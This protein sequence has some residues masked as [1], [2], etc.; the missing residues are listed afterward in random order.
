MSADNKPQAQYGNVK[1][2]DSS[3]TF[4]A[5]RLR[6]AYSGC[7][8]NTIVFCV[9]ENELEFANWLIDLQNH[10]QDTVSRDP[11]KFK[12]LSRRG[13]IF[14]RTVITPSR[15]PDMYAD[16]FRCRLATEKSTETGEL[17]VSTV[18]EGVENVYG[19]FAGSHITPII[20]VGYYKVGDEFGL[21]FVV[22]KGVYEPRIPRAQQT[23]ETWEIDDDVNGNAT[24]S[25]SVSGV[26]GEFSTI[27]I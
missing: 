3:L 26:G 23:E 2:G 4:T 10:F 8:W 14:P 15:D 19:V 27:V 6:V 12:V 7:K 11:V 17:V 18:M 1:Y 25:S 24:G 9:D 22:L 16:E 20:K 5:P 13:A 21:K